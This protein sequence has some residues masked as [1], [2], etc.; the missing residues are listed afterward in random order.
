LKC[1]LALHHARPG[2]VTEL[3]HQ[4]C[5]DLCHIFS[6]QPRVRPLTLILLFPYTS[7]ATKPL[8]VG[9]P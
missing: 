1:L 2:H 4:L 8:L 3:F 7:R 6:P 9:R 5:A